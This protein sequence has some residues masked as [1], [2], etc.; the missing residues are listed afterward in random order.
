MVLQL[1]NHALALA[2]ALCLG[3]A[4]ASPHSQLASRDLYVP[5][6]TCTPLVYGA[7]NTPVGG[8]VCITIQDGTATVTF[9]T[10]SGVTYGTTHVWVG[11]SPP[12]GTNPGQ[13]PG[14]PGQY[15]YQ[16]SGSTCTFPVDPSWR[17]CGK[18]LY[19]ATHAEISGPATG[20]QTAW[21]SGPCIVAGAP[22]NCAKFWTFTTE[23]RCVEVITYTPITTSTICTVILT[24]LLTKTTTIPAPSPTTTTATCTNPS[25]G[26]VTTEGTPPSTSIDWACPTTTG[27]CAAP[28]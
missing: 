2:T 21:G 19:I 17:V 26:I 3:V 4:Q 13:V 14:P 1:F 20:G 8:N 25:P 5:P 10:V 27:T 11:T 16:C 15:P 18:T 28:T 24:S 22:G 7:Q 12:T 6:T 23:C 9:P